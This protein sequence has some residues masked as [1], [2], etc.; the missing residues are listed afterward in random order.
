MLKNKFITFDF[1]LKM[2]LKMK[3]LNVLLITG[4]LLVLSSSCRTQTRVIGERNQKS[5]EINLNTPDVLIKPLVADLDISQEKKTTSYLADLNLNMSEI[6]QN[7]QAKFMDEHN[8]DVIINPVYKKVTTVENSNITKIQY[9]VSGF[10]ATIKKIE[11]ND[12]LSETVYDYNKMNFDIKRDEYTY[13]D[14]SIVNGSEVFLS[15]GSGSYSGIEIGYFP[16]VSNGIWYYGSVESYNTDEQTLGVDVTYDNGTKAQ[17]PWGGGP[18]TF[19]MSS[20][21]LG[22]GYRAELNKRISSNIFGGL[23]YGML[24]LDEQ[25]DIQNIPTGTYLLNGL[26]TIGIRAGIGV[27]YVIF[28]NIQV[29]GKG[30]ANLNLLKLSSDEIKAGD[31]VKSDFDL[32]EI[33][34][35][36]FALGIKLRF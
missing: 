34:L 26:N 30:F 8:C 16:E 29:F 14:E 4:F 1:Q 25:I 21:S 32:S 10:P 12:I 23:N 27:D 24:K 33:S 15:L 28:R 18:L 3:Q 9:E 6:K 36:N 35:V 17:L 7:A 31:D 5:P 13:K 19:N 2:K 22:A 20:I 11:Q